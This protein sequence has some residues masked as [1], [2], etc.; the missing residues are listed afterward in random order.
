MLSSEQ[1]LKKIGENL[2]KS[3]VEQNITLEAIAAKTLIAKR[4]LVAIEKGNVKDLPEPFYTKALITKYAQA[5]GVSVVLE[6]EENQVEN[7]PQPIRAS[8]KNL[9]VQGSKKIPT[10]QLKSRHLYLIYLAVVIVSVKAIASFVEKPV[11]V[12]NEITPKNEQQV[13]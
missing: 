13:S 5:I 11:V 8:K 6:D 1:K 9:D 12:T 3:R 4:V 10:I 7:Q 2:Y